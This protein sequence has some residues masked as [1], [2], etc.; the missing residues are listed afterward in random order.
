MATNL[1]KSGQDQNGNSIAGESNFN[2]T[3]EI[4]LFFILE[5]QQLYNFKSISS[6]YENCHRNEEVVR[7][8][9]FFAT[10]ISQHLQN[11]MQHASLPYV[12]I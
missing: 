2:C 5:M 6:V 8:F 1:L 4:C 12:S 11:V 10:S 3:N 7:C 9:F